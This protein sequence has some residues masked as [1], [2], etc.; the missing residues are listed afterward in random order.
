MKIDNSTKLNVHIL[1]SLL[2][3]ATGILLL[4]YMMFVEDEPSPIPPLLIVFGAGWFFFSRS[5]HA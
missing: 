2:V 3:T 4:A 1:L 5:K